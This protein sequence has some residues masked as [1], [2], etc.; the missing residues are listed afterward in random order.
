M[1]GE[2][3]SSLSVPTGGA[4]AGGAP[5]RT[6][7]SEKTFSTSRPSHSHITFRS[8]LPLPISVI[9]RTTSLTVP[10]TYV[11]LAAAPKKREHSEK[12]EKLIVSVCTVAP[13]SSRV[14]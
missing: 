7:R 5:A 9:P 1:T 12:F 14:S 10:D 13:T 8:V 3:A 11:V 2:P 4:I 6:L